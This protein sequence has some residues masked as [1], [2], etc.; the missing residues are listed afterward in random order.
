MTNA[1]RARSL[2]GQRF[3]NGLVRALLA[4]PGIARLVGTRLVTLYVIGRTSKRRYA[5]P[6]AYL[7]DGDDLLIGTPFGWGRNLRSG[8]PI[9]L[10]LKGRLRSADVKVDTAEP[11]V[12]RGYAHMARANPAFAKFNRIRLGKDGTPDH[13]D[14]RQAWLGGARVIRL[15][16]RR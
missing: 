9:Q 13:D 10:R 14:L 5:I 1:S 16:P 15:S 8:E 4:T 11:E 6:V 2:P 3:A 7:P 12:V